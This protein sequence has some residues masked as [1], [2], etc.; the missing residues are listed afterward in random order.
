VSR[1]RAA[2]APDEP[3]GP[4]AV[5]EATGTAV[6]QLFA[7]VERYPE[8]RSQANVLDLQGRSSASDILADRRELYNDTVYRYDSRIQQFPT[9]LLAGLFGGGR[10]N[11]SPR[12]PAK[13]HSRQSSSRA[14]A[15]SGLTVALATCVC[16]RLEVAVGSGRAERQAPDDGRGFEEQGVHERSVE[17]IDVDDHGPAA[18]YIQERQAEALVAGRDP[19][20][21]SVADEGHGGILGE[22]HG[23]SQP[24]GS[25]RRSGG[26]RSPIAT[27]RRPDDEPGRADH[28]TM[29]RPSPDTRSGRDG[30]STSGRRRGRPEDADA[31][32]LGR[33]RLEAT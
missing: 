4:G 27:G 9:N 10:A 13:D 19:A 18:G 1:L 33:G 21:L 7:V 29:S 31:G 28:S 26:P 5:S 22:E 3:I 25:G 23:A 16:D 20:E 17:G 2:Y 11:S 15:G 8:I 6:R 32:H 14:I 12:R 30:Q 24:S